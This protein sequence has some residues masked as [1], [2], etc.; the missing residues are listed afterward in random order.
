M[1]LPYLVPFSIILPLRSV[2]IEI[3]FLSLIYFQNVFSW[4][5][6]NTVHISKR[7]P[8][9]GRRRKRGGGRRKKRVKTKRRRKETVRGSERWRRWWKGVRWEGLG[10][11]WI[12]SRAKTQAQVWGWWFWLDRTKERAGLMTKQNGGL[13]IHFSSSLLSAPPLPLWSLELYNKRLL[14]RSN[15][16]KVLDWYLFS[17]CDAETE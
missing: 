3:S 6:K 8:W 7:K 13:G 9:R 15:F 5:K 16:K 14:L 2:L 1:L 10:R 4:K 12:K 11:R 17:F